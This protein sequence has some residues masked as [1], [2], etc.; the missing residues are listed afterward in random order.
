MILNI[1]LWIMF[2][3]VVGWIASL[4]MRTDEEQGAFANII[5]GIIGAFIGGIVSRMLGGPGV[6]G[7]NFVSLLIAVL[8]ATVLLFFIRLMSGGQGTTRT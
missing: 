3:A 6:S 8:G 5:I 2:G 1:V 7:F 4:I